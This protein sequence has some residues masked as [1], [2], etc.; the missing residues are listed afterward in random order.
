MILHICE[1]EINYLNE[2]LF[3]WFF[4]WSNEDRLYWKIK[5]HLMV[6]EKGTKQWM[7]WQQPSKPV[8]FIIHLIDENKIRK[9]VSLTCTLDWRTF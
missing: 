4:N 6:F 8:R 3:K 7:G 9:Y 2:Q 5:Y 1:T